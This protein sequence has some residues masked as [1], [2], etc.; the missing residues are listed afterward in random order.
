[1]RAVSAGDALAAQPLLQVAEPAG[2]SWGAGGYYEV[3]LGGPTDWIYPPLHDAGRRMAD[4]ASR[5]AGGSPLHQR[6]LAQLGRELLL[7]Q[8]SDWP[9]ILKN[10]TAEEYARRRLL[11]HLTAFTALA[12]QVEEGAID[13]EALLALEDRDNLFPDLDPRLWS[14]P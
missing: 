9:F 1:L 2:T 8:A 11:D 14:R 10:R 4:L 6:A 7:A 12:W 5:S 13:E 3:W